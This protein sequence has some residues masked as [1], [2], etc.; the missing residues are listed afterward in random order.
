MNKLEKMSSLTLL[1]HFEDA[2]CDKNYN[3]S[4]ENYNE[5]GFS[6]EELRNEILNR[7]DFINE[8]EPETGDYE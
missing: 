2:V 6:Y 1:E 4:S 8:I 3:P 7:M 5:S